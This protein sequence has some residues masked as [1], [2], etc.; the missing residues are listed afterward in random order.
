MFTNAKVEI[1]GG[2]RQIVKKE[3]VPIGINNYVDICKF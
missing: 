1:N 2:K 3:L